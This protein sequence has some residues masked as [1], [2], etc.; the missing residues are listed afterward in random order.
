MAAYGHAEMEAAEA[1]LTQQ[2]EL[3]RFVCENEV[4]PPSSPSPSYK[5]ALALTTRALTWL[6]HSRLL[7]SLPSQEFE[8]RPC[9]NGVDAKTLE[10]NAIR[11]VEGARR[12]L[13]GEEKDT[14]VG[15]AML[16]W[17]WLTVCLRAYLQAQRADDINLD[18]VKQIRG[19]IEKEVEVSTEE[20]KQERDRLREEAEEH[21]E[22]IQKMP[23]LH[24]PEE[25]EGEDGGG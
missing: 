7:L 14:C 21:F 25:S 15:S 20:D 8:N 19:A 5:L 11:D 17:K 24:R 18:E 10:E 16:K 22:N 3:L 4:S 6:D 13:F 23:N 9:V 12:L 1:D 2:I